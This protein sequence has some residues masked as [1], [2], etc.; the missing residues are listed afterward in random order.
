MHRHHGRERRRA[1]R[2][3]SRRSAGS[4]PGRSFRGVPDA[5]LVRAGAR[6]RRSCG[7]RSSAT[8]ATQLLEAELRA[9]GRNRVLR[10]PAAASR[11][12]RDLLDAPA[13]HRVLA[14]RPRAGEGRAGGP[15]RLP[16]RSARRGR[17]RGTTPSR[18]DFERVLR[19]RNALLRSGVRDDEA[20]TTLDVFDDQLVARRRRARPGPA[21]AGRAARARGRRRRT[22]RWPARRRRCRRPR[23]EA[24]WAEGPLDAG[25]DDVDG[26]AARRA[27]RAPAPRSSTGA[28]P[29][30]GPT[31]TTGGSRSTASTPGR[32]ASQGEQR[33]LALALRLA[34]H[35]VVAERD[36]R[37]TRCCCST[38][39]SASSTPTARRRS[40]PHLPAGQTL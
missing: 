38:T 26:T 8:A 15:A 18:T 12:Q 3:C 31:A 6:R 23:Y 19:Q 2:A 36:R 34:G 14:R 5:A 24:E 21:R 33:T 25:A 37:A 7:P 13:R 20:R 1:R 16:R 22:R 9:V 10:E 30:S 27:R 40:S 39:C 35:R 4:R 32:H 17:A 11:A 29:S 28:S